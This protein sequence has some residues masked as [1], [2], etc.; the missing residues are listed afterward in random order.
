MR[1]SREA[2]PF[3][4]ARARSLAPAG[5]GGPGKPLAAPV[6]R[7][8]AYFRGRPSGCLP[9]RGLVLVLSV[10]VAVQ[11]LPAFPAHAG[12][13]DAAVVFEDRDGNG[14]RDPGEPP[15]AGV[16]VSDG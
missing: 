8:T 6:A 10:F 16:R 12:A 1:A 11:A 13:C 3:P 14:V 9:M 5:G 7:Q 15:L 2:G 4:P